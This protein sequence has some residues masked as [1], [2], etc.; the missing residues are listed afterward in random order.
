MLD[1]IDKIEEEDSSPFT[2]KTLID[3]TKLNTELN[4][5]VNKS[6]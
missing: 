3:E 1:L 5:A 4:S 6:N 2:A